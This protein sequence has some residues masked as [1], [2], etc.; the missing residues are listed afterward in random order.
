MNWFGYYAGPK[1]TLFYVIGLKY[2]NPIGYCTSIY[3]E[4]PQTEEWSQLI[5]YLYLIK[6]E[7]NWQKQLSLTTKYRTFRQNCI[8]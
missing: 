4:A 8:L 5:Y 6:I 3:C 2:K 1:S 7:N